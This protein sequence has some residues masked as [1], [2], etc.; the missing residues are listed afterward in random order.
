MTNWERAMIFMLAVVCVAIVITS[1]LP[2]WGYT[3]D[4]AAGA[5]LIV[6]FSVSFVQLVQ[7]TVAQRRANR[8]SG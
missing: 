4:V 1:S 5:G 6:T 7:R 2:W 8:L 3:L